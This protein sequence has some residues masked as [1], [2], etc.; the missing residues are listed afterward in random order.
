MK[1]ADKD[2]FEY[3]SETRAEFT[4]LSISTEHKGLF[5]LRKR[6]QEALSTS[7][8]EYC[9]M[10][11]AERRSIIWSESMLNSGSSTGRVN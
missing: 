6:D 10:L 3:R 8:L 4:I 9:D 1:H 5:C 11:L 2:S 7:R